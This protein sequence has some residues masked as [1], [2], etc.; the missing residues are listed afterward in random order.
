MLLGVDGSTGCSVGSCTDHDGD[1]CKRAITQ[2]DVA[3]SAMLLHPEFGCWVS[4]YRDFMACAN[5]A[6]CCAAIARGESLKA[7][8]AA[9]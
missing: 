6:G 8:H 7:M 3:L 2:P 1:P 5:E 9:V 4:F